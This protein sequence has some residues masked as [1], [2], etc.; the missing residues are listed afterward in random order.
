M[1]NGKLDP[2]A[3]DLHASIADWMQL[4]R[5]SLIGTRPN[6]MPTRPEWGDLSISKDGRTLYLHI[7]VWPQSGVIELEGLADKMKAAIFLANGRSVPFSQAGSTV[8]F[9]LPSQPICQ[10]D[11]VIQ[12]TLIR[13]NA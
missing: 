10:Y 7:L 13:P 2:Q 11:T 4:N 8:S 12:L 1:P 5:E 9:N 6:P 3:V